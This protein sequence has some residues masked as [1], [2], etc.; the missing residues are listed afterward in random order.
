[1]RERAREVL[2]AHPS[3]VDVTDLLPPLVIEL[4]NED[5]KEDIGEEDDWDE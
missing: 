2:K 4:A 3:N 1:V 5:E